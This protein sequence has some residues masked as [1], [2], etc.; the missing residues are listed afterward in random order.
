MVNV[1]ALHERDGL[2]VLAINRESRPGVAALEEAEL[3]RLLSL[4]QAHLVATR[5]SEVV[6][7]LL[8]FHRDAPYDGEE[9]LALRAI[10]SVP[11]LYLDQV[12]VA[13]GLRHTG[14]GRSL[15]E[16]IGSVARAAGV[17]MLCCEVNRRPPNPGSRAFHGKLGF[18]PVGRLATRDGRDVEL[19]ARTLC[20]E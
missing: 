9:F 17:G 5:G 18:R 15:Y 10:L 8:A 19:L 12:A 2:Q 20:G 6:G 11:Y 7:Y 3:A 1:R 16:Q 14:V 4:P 13:P